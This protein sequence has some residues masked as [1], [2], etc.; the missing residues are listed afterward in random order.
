MAREFAPGH[1]E[2][3]PDTTECRVISRSMDGLCLCLNPRPQGCGHME[4]FH[5]LAF[6]FHPKRAEF[7]KRIVAESGG[8]T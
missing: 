5:L 1:D 7:A 3:L 2:N 6:C 4:Q 8:N